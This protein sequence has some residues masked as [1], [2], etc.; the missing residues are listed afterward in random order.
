[1]EQG[2]F[3]GRR[4]DLPSAKEAGSHQSVARWRII[5]EGIADIIRFCPPGDRD[6][7]STLQAAWMH[8]EHRHLGLIAPPPPMLIE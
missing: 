5:S 8:A 4:Y 7:I 6:L 3:K 2:F 1:V